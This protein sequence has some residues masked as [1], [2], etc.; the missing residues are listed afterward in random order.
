MTALWL[1]FN[2]LVY[3]AMSA[4]FL[5][6]LPQTT[7][8]MGFSEVDG[9]A[10]IELVTVYGGLGAGLALLFLIAGLKKDK[11]PFALV[12]LMMS[13][14]FFALGRLAGIG[15]FPVTSSSTY[16]LLGFELIGCFLSWVL[17]RKNR[18]V[19]G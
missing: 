9:S 11:R 4:A 6:R 16:Y 17:W 13:Y 10:A 19:D 2:G 14:L 5:F 18:N 3:A 15:L 8:S 12:I 1:F 7:Q